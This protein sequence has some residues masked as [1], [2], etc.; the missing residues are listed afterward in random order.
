MEGDF[1]RGSLDE[2]QLAEE[3]EALAQITDG[4]S[5]IDTYMLNKAEDGGGRRKTDPARY[6]M[7][8]GIVVLVAL[9]AVQYIHASR[10][11]F[12]T[13]GAFNQ[14]I[15]P[16]Y[17][18]MGKPVTPEWDVKGWR[19]EST[20][21]SVDEGQQVLTIVSAIGNASD[22]PLPYPLV[23]VS[24]TDRWEEIIGSKVLEP[25]EYLAGDLDP[26]KPVAPNDRFQA[27]IAIESPSAD[28]TGFKLNVCYRITPFHHL[29]HRAVLHTGESALADKSWFQRERP[30]SAG[31]DWW[32]CICR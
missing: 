8:A 5:L 6:A 23:H 18:A 31:T 13:Y 7:T 14:T 15:G 29:F 16:V 30:A 27:V 21:G 28:A 22:E 2:Q 19:F 3:Q 1:V 32:S 17:R 26:R 9:L 11:D 24:L 20:N 12:A 25:N 10:S 4:D